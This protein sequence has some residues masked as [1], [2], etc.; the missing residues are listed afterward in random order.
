MTYIDLAAGWTSFIYSKISVHS[1]LACAYTDFLSVWKG[2]LLVGNDTVPRE[3]FNTLVLSSE[4]D[5][6]GVSLTG[7][8][9][10]EFI[11]VSV[12]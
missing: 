1:F 12:F 7:E 11:L 9:D 5:E 3:A 6:T 10:T 2:S 4:K 8:D